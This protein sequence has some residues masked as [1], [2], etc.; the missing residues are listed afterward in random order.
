M[1]EILALN[2]ERPGMLLNTLQSTGQN[3]LVPRA[4]NAYTEKPCYTTDAGKLGYTQRDL[5]W[6]GKLI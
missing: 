5:Q 4:N 3:G 6:R 2:E 1:G